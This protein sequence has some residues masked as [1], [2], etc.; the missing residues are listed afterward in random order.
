M[1]YCNALHKLYGIITMYQSVHRKAT[2]LFVKDICLPI[3]TAN[4]NDLMTFTKYNWFQQ[5]HM[6]LFCSIYYYCFLS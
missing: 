2:L 5:V 6:G 4:D 1:M 3:V